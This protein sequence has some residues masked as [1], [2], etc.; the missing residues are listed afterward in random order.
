MSDIEPFYNLTTD[1]NEQAFKRGHVVPPGAVNLAWIKSPVINPETN[2]VVVDTSTI[3]PENVETPQSIVGYANLLG[4]LEDNQ[5]NRVLT[6]RYP[7]IADQFS[8]E[9]D[10]TDLDLTTE[11]IFPYVHVSR[12]FHLDTAGLVPG[13]ILT[14]FSSAQIKVVDS[15]GNIYA[16]AEGNPLFR[17]KI[18]PIYLPWQGIANSTINTPADFVMAYRVH[19][20]IDTNIHSNL[21]LNYDKVEVTENGQFVDQVINYQEIL[22]PQPYYDYRPEEAEVADPVNRDQTWYSSKSVALKEQLLGLPATDTN[23]YEIV[24]PKK[25][26]PDPRNFQLFRWRVVCS[27]SQN[28]TTATEADH[29]I[30]CGVII[31]N[32]MP[33]S[34]I[35][36]VFNILS[37]NTVN[38]TQAVFANPLNQTQS[39]L[40]KTNNEYWYVNIDTITNDQLAQFDY[41]IWS[42][43][44]PTFDFTPYLGQ[45][46]YFTKTLGKVL[47]IDTDSYLIPGGLGI[48]TTAGTSPKDGTA[49]TTP[50]PSNNYT[51]TNTAG[52]A[53][54]SNWMP[55]IFLG[56]YQN[57]T[58]FNPPPPPGSGWQA[59]ALSNPSS[60]HLEYMASNGTLYWQSAFDINGST[61]D[62]NFTARAVVS[63]FT[64]RVD[65]SVYEGVEASR[66]LPPIFAGVGGTLLNPVPPAGSGWTTTP[67]TSDHL[68]YVAT[69]NNT[70]YRGF[71]IGPA[72][73]TVNPAITFAGNVETIVDQFQSWYPTSYPN[74]SANGGA[75]G[76]NVSPVV[77]G[78]PPTGTY[79]GL[80]GALYNIPPRPLNL[81]S[82][83]YAV[84]PTNLSYYLP[85]SENNPISDTDNGVTYNTASNIFDAS[86]LNGW[87][88]NTSEPISA[89]QTNFGTEG[90]YVQYLLDLPQGSNT[91]VSGQLSTLTT[92]QISQSVDI[93]TTLYTGTKET[94]SQPT[95]TTSILG[96]TVG[97]VGSIPITLPTLPNGAVL[98]QVII[99]ASTSYS[100]AINGLS[101][102]ISGPSNTTG[103]GS[104]VTSLNPN[105]I[106]NQTYTITNGSAIDLTQ[107]FSIAYTDAA[108]I[109]GTVTI[110]TVFSYYLENPTSSQTVANAPSAEFPFLSPVP[111]MVESG[112][113]IVSTLGL[114]QSCC[115][116]IPGSAQLLYNIALY[117]TANRALATYNAS[118]HSSS[119]TF[120]SPWQNSW[121]INITDYPNVLTNYEKN[122]YNFFYLPEDSATPVNVWQRQLSTQTCEDL[123]NSNIDQSLL[124]AVE[125]ANRTY[126]LEVTNSLVETPSVIYPQSIPYAWTRA[127][128]PTLQVPMDY[129]TY[130]I[131][132]TE[133]QGD[134]SSG[135]YIARSYPDEPYLCQAR[136]YLDTDN[137]GSLNVNWTASGT[138]TLTYNTKYYTPPQS[139]TEQ[140]PVTSS[141]EVVLNAADNGLP[142]GDYIETHLPYTG[143]AVPGSIQTYQDDNYYSVGT[144]PCWP[145]FGLIGS[146]QLGSTGE[147]V[148]FIQDALN[149][150]NDRGYWQL[151]AGYLVV[152][153]VYGQATANAVLA[154][155]NHFFAIYRDGIVDA[156]T[157]SIIGSQ[158]LRSG[159][160]DLASLDNSSD[161]H[162]F[163]NWPWL[164]MQ[165]QN[166]SDGNPSS[167][168]QKRSWAQ[169]GPTYIWDLLSVTL[170]QQYSVHGI[171]VIPWVEGLTPTMRI[172]GVHAWVSNSITA[173]GGYNPANMM[174]SNLG[175]RAADNESIYIPFNPIQ[176]DQVFVNIG[177]DGPAYAGYTTRVFGVR[178]IQVHATVS[179]TSIV[180]ETITVPGYYTT[181]T[182][183]T[184]I[185]IASSGTAT[186]TFARD[187]TANIA[188]QF[189]G[190]GTI[191]D[192]QWNSIQI[193]NPQL[194]ASITPTGLI[195]I[196]VASANGS[197][198]VQG[199]LTFGPLLPTNIMSNTYPGTVF[200]TPS[201]EL[202][203]PVVWMTPERKI[204]PIP[205]VG[206]IS[207]ADGLKLLCD[208]NGNPIGFPEMPTNTNLDQRHYVNL[209]LSSYGTATSIQ[210]GFYDINAKEFVVDANGL[211]QINYLD[212]MNRGPNN[213]YVGVISTYEVDTQKALPNSDDSPPIPN[214]M[215]MPAYGVQTLQGSKIGLTELPQNLSQDNIWPIPVQTGN[216]FRTINIVPT[217]TSILTGYLSHYQ[218]TTVTAYYSVPEANDNGWSSIYGEPNIDVV[219]ESPIIQ[220]LSTLQVRQV[221]ILMKRQPTIYNTLAD[222]VRPIFTVY[223]RIAIADN[224]EPLSWSDIKG[225]DVANGLINLNTPLLSSDPNLVAVDYTTTQ[226]IY[227][228]KEYNGTIIN[229]NPYSSQSDIFANK[230]IYVYIVPEY[231][232][233][234]NGSIIT[235]SQ[236]TRTLRYT[237]DISIFDPTHPSYDPTVV[238]L[239][240]IYITTDFD[241]NDLVILDS[242]RRGG[243]GEDGT[244]DPALISILKDAI[245]YWDVS[246]GTGMSYQDGCYIIVRL[247]AEL[248]NSF[249]E[250][251]IVAAIRRNLSAGVQFDIE[252]TEGNVW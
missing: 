116:G 109:L 81:P 250:S 212:Y 165:Y 158:I 234:A 145:F 62:V 7:A 190:N 147:A 8:I 200:H 238:Q 117:A 209:S 73:A 39:A 183:T 47:L 229:L 188:P 191:S 206:M 131:R 9:G 1:G 36:Q 237:F 43:D 72:Y 66:W 232:I 102:V 5:G 17:I 174:L 139:I 110:N 224:W 252:D 129:E 179:R 18:I 55:Q 93:T 251:E 231:I 219:K 195:G 230:P 247:P 187:Y 85:S 153:G 159:R 44:T 46:Q 194:S 61:V 97:E 75:I 126:T 134:Y 164:R 201:Y 151:P 105:G 119:F 239:G 34:S 156:E 142:G 240:I 169:G 178:D 222:P 20:F 162:T 59:Q 175:L 184:Q 103:A 64:N 63:T 223:T 189:N 130:I 104:Q 228:F 98:S 205:E 29:P 218:G 198:Q 221:P 192:I 22:N 70:Y 57:I 77:A 100:D 193:D 11:H 163:Y 137:V 203:T 3:V 146:Y 235:S 204:N 108:A 69:D 41:L 68:A 60:N 71:P 171:T 168:W 106:L 92:A 197:I 88:I 243:G 67:I 210:I 216:F 107:P 214:A 32:N 244:T 37:S 181:N 12:F 241:I 10:I 15:G 118:N 2:M 133:V 99:S 213:I 173:F 94:I 30:N 45:I 154:F 49:V 91:L 14:D 65:D 4:K 148:E 220:D 111:L 217:T 56:I 86:T 115:M 245:N 185:P 123:I 101:A 96:K 143:V 172:D 114:P 215:I 225:F 33:T 84:T 87:T 50:I 166:V 52:L 16:D 83:T 136:A 53:D 141:V 157:F 132:E 40:S 155:Q 23:G 161:Y 202:T 58:N 140:V 236:Q 122:N 6:E 152:D 89:F 90:G 124:S 208:L 180:S 226:N 149:Y 54:V 38:I 249:S 13:T 182:V 135:S 127:Y 199:S 82:T 79:T 78:S 242:R 160:T 19:A 128:T 170:G 48:T 167:M 42:P 196:G 76:T 28:F 112:P 233:D 26:L 121:V 207:K 24:V 113:L 125:G 80:S 144:S 248:K 31:T 177:Q 35:A 25:A 21:Y 186:V 138:A 227:L 211:P 27:F 51:P 74:V 176:A 246:Y 120:S 95:T 150:F